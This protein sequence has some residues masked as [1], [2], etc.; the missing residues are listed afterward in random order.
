MI[1][2]ITSGQSLSR[3]S[4][5]LEAAGLIR[6]AT[7]FKYYCDFSG[8]GQKLQIGTYTLSPSMTVDAIADLLTTGDGNPLVRNITLIPG[9]TLETF[10]EYLV[11]RGVLTDVT[12]FL[13]LCQ[14]GE[15]FA[16][17]TYVDE[18]LNQRDRK[19]KYLLEGYLAANTYEVYTSATP[20]EIIRKLLSQTDSLWLEEYQERADAL[21]MTMNEVFTLASLIEKEA[22]TS[23]FALVSAVFHNRLKAGMAL[24]S[25]V[26]IHYITGIQKMNL[27]AEDLAVDSPYNT[28]THKG[29]PPGPICAPSANAIQAALYPNE[30]Y[31]AN[32]YL[33][34]CAKEPGSGELYFSRTL[35]EHE[36]AVA[37]Y[38]PLWAEYDKERGIE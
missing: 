36:Q 28:Y 20:E 22:G 27:S 8:F 13:E 4:K 10:A 19:Q 16:D 2:D 6:S 38:A 26:T 9:W 15:A 30:S 24:G 25:D 32:N 23:D 21:G 5:N 29:L 17:Y 1:F 35:A 7:F 12:E 31:V 18:L 3:V 33:Y 37:I 11:K 34:F 14:T